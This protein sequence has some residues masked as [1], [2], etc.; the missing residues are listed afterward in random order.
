MARVILPV[1]E[2]I[3]LVYIQARAV[4]TWRKPKYL[5]Q[6]G[7]G[8]EGIMWK[9]VHSDTVKST[10]QSTVYIT[11]DILSALRLYLC[12]YNAVSSLGTTLSDG[13]VGY[14]SRF[15]RFIFWYDGDTAGYTGSAKGMKKLGLLGKATRI[16]T[17]RDPKLYSNREIGSIITNHEKCSTQMLK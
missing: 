10:L 8:K 5:N 15:K 13:Q 6:C 1:Y 17:E 4:H 16:I 9:G 14:L 12:G 11:E 3:D 7:A 2:G